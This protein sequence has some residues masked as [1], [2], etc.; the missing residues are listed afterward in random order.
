MV[1]RALVVAG[2]RDLVTPLL[3]AQ[4]HDEQGGPGVD[5]LAAAHRKGDRDA[6]LGGGEHP[7]RAGGQADR[8]ADGDDS[9]AGHGSS[10]GWGD[11]TST[12]PTGRM[13]LTRHSRVRRPPKSAVS[14]AALRLFQ[15]AFQQPAGN[16]P[17]RESLVGSLE[18]GQ[19]ARV[20]KVP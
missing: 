9:G 12:N 8:R 1:A 20:E 4:G 13:S 16:H 14:V 11:P 17:Q 6:G 5:R 2:D 3:G 7:R 18:E 15:R 10:R 19:D